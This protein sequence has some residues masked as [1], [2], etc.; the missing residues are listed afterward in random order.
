MKI[1]CTRILPKPGI[2]LLKEAGVEVHCWKEERDLSEAELVEKCRDADGLIAIGRTTIDRGF[3]EAN[4]H[5]KVVS[6]FSVGY[7]NVD[8]KAAEELGIPVGHTPDVLS[9]ATADTAFLLLQMTA[10]KALFHHKRII[11]GEWG[12]FNPEFELG[13]DLKGKTLGVFGLGNIGYEMARSCFAAFDMK[14]IYHNRS[15]NEKADHAFGAKW[16]SF[17]QM[18]QQ[19][20]VIS[21]HANLSAETKGKFNASAFAQMKPSAIFINTARGG[22]HNEIDLIQAL[23]NKTIW[24]AGLDVTNPEPMLPENPLLQ[25]SNVTVT[26]H[27]GSA[28]KETRDAM[29]VLAAG[30]ALKGLKGEPLLARV[31]PSAS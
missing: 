30:N 4:R 6:L 16:V 21:V 18:L 7:D 23:Q 1:F 17:E 10:R 11:K 14:I 25:M 8:V 19:S 31:P 12:F 27:I 13:T 29:A 15:R 3:L 20:D 2:E 24:G 5:L 9:K 26:P 28:T 22:L